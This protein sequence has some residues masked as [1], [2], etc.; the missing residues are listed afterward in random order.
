ME[1]ILFFLALH[2]QV[3]VEA[4]LLNQFQAQTLAEMVVLAVVAALF[5]VADLLVG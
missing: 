1:V 4:V 2:R 5:Q 3:V